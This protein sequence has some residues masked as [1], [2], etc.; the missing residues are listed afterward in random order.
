MRVPGGEHMSQA[1]AE[2]F[3]FLKAESCSVGL[4]WPPFVWDVWFPT[5]S[6]TGFLEGRADPAPGC[7]FLT[8]LLEDHFYY[9]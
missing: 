9:L 5:D 6:H 1:P 3:V 7:R 2:A 4:P 8:C